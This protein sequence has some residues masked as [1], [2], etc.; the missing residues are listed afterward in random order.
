[1]SLGA[2]GI[3]ILATMKYGIDISYD[4]SKKSISDNNA[5]SGVS[6]SPP[7]PPIP[8]SESSTSLANSIPSPN[9]VIEEESLEVL[10]QEVQE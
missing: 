7:L 9:I 8:G 4:P 1:M 6:S 2:A 3:V 5:V 10:F